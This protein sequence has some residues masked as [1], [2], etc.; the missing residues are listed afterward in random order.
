MQKRFPS[1]LTNGQGP[2]LT[3]KIGEDREENILESENGNIQKTLKRFRSFRYS[4]ILE[5]VLSGIVAGVVV[6]LFR[7]LLEK[8]DAFRNGAISFCKAHPFGVVLWLAAVAIASIAVYF[9]LKW[10]PYISGSGIPQVEGEMLGKIDQNWWR[11]LLAKCTGGLLSIGCGLSLGREGPSIQLGAMAAKGF[12]RLNHR[13][14]TEERL[15]I[16]C[17][18]SAGLAAAFNAPLAGVLFSLEEIHKNFSPEVL[19][20]TMAASVTADFISR[21][22]FGLKPVFSFQVASHLPLY[23]YGHVVFLGILIGLLGVLYNISIKTSQNLYQKIPAR[24]RLLVSFLCA[25]CLAFLYPQVLGGGHGLAVNI[26]LGGFTVTVLC[27]LFIVKFFFSMV[28]FGSG[29]P[30]GIFLPLLVLGAMIGS[31]YYEGASIFFPLPEGLL[32]NFIIMGMAGYFSAIVRAPI[33]GIVLISE[34]T[35]SFSHLLTLSIIALLAY[36][37][38]DLLKCPPIYDQL[39]HRMLAGKKDTGSK[40]AQGEKVLLEEIIHHGSAAE[41]KKLSEIVWPETCLVVSLMR[42]DEEFVPKGDAVFQAEDKI[43]LLCSEYAIAA[44]QE[45]LEDQCR[46][47]HN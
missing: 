41:N 10:E 15:L 24:F 6:V 26:S 27:A 3:K 7:L 35:G 4:L 2:F 29:A 17:G 47:I 44:A 18:A 5:G 32:C 30:G 16:T 14:K 28:S 38:P 11:I 36:L 12:S 23:Q 21:N 39:L 42:G 43:V 20:S 40:E 45:V 37:I 33:T 8:A 46:A 31:I 19:L 34:M 9:L 25:G 1:I 13:M 22:I